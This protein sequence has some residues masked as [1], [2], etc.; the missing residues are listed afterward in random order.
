[1][2]QVLKNKFMADTFPI[3]LFLSVLYLFSITYL[4]LASLSIA[5]AGSTWYK[6]HFSLRVFLKYTPNTRQKR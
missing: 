3:F 4:L 6:L 2:P 1:V 5:K